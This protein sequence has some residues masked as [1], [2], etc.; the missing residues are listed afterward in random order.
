MQLGFVLAL[1]T[2]ILLAFSNQFSLSPIF[3]VVILFFVLTLVQTQKEKERL[4]AEF[5][6]RNNWQ[7]IDAT[8]ESP[9]VPPA[10]KGVGHSPKI[11]KIIHAVINSQ[12]WHL[13]RYEYVTGSGK[14]KNVHITTILHKTLNKPLPYILLDSKKNW[15]GIARVPVGCHQISLEGDFSKYF[16]LFLQEGS[17]IDVLSL[18]TPDVM[19]A[20]ID[21]G[22]LYDIE[23]LDDNLYIVAVYDQRTADNME[24][25]LRAAALISGEL[26]HNTKTFQYDPSKM[27]PHGRGK[28]AA[29]TAQ[30][31]RYGA[32][33]PVIEKTLT[34]IGGVFIS[35]FLFFA[36]F[37]VWL[38]VFS[39]R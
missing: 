2:T 6:G 31:A 37:L 13:L 39:S 36:V 12:E 29:I 38:V 19:A 26:N 1:I 3:A 5:A 32:R 22:F 9:Y 11:S 15:G 33:Y 7:L 10:I 35:L 18:L 17:H 8:I 14:N 34:V 24:A 23:I 27:V 30:T 16:S 21:K 20:L 4:W 28:V 25:I